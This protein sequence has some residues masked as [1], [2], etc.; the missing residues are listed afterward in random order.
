MDLNKLLVPTPDSTGKYLKESVL[1]GVFN[2]FA[3]APG[4][5][6]EEL[7]EINLSSGM[8]YWF[9]KMIALRTGYFYESDYKGARQH[10]TFGA[11]VKYKVLELDA[12]Y[13]L[14]TYSNFVYDTWRLGLAFGLNSFHKT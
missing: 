3:D 4:G 12:S 2:S 6:S 5:L 10:F 11:G 8:E 13:S 14:N 7:Q 1:E 9:R